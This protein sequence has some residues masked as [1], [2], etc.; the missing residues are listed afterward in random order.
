LPSTSS[1]PDGFSAQQQSLLEAFAASAATAVAT[2]QSAADERRVQRLAAAEAE[3]ARWARELHD[4][5]LQGLGI[6]RLTLGAA[7][8]D[9]RPETIARV[10]GEALDQLGSDIANLRALITD[11]RPAALDQLGIEAAVM[12]LVDRVKLL[13]LGVDVS[14]D[15]TYEQGRASTRYISELE[16]AVYRIVQEALTNATKHGRAKRAVVEVHEDER[17]V[18]VAIRDDGQGFDPNEKA[19][20]FGLPGMRERAELL[21]GTLSIESAAG[22]GTTVTALLPVRRRSR[23]YGA[24]EVVGSDKT[25]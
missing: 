20:G 25:G 12:A 13:G 9:G 17:N 14:V 1:R 10:V 5:T 23:T 7:Q 6:L 22:E 16:T 21:G 24:A 3:R 11:L 8:R 15:L 18:R 19:T 2:A 4:D